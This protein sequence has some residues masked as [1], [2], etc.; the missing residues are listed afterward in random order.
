MADNAE[1]ELLRKS[2]HVIPFPDPPAGTLFAMV[3]RRDE[4][5]HER[6]GE[7][8]EDVLATAPRRR[9]SS[10]KKRERKEKVC[11]NPPRIHVCLK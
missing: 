1:E 7:L 8:L 6:V 11:L 5:A 4:E 10:A 9:S 3:D 2:P